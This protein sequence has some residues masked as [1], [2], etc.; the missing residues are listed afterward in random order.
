VTDSHTLVPH[1]PQVEVI[2]GQPYWTVTLSEDLA[3]EDANDPD[4]A[5]AM[6]LRAKG[7]L[8]RAIAGRQD[9]ELSWSGFRLIHR[10]IVNGSLVVTYAVPKDGVRPAGSP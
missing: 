8:A 6:V 7:Q 2:N 5:S 4:V 3:G 10:Q 9:A 1:D